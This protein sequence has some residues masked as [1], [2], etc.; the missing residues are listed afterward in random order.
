MV[1]QDNVLVPR[2]TSWFGYYYDDAFNSILGPQQIDL[3]I[4]DLIG[5]RTLDEVGRL[6]YIYI[7]VSGGHL[8]I[9]KSDLKKL[10]VPHSISSAMPTNGNSEVN[11]PHQH[12]VVGRNEERV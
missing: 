10:V 5:L 2:E 8:G 6:K 7:S 11:R 12:G 9:S 3:Y 4:E 1:K